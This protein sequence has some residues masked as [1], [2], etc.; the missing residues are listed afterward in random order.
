VSLETSAKINLGWIKP[1]IQWKGLPVTRVVLL[2]LLAGGFVLSVV[3]HDSHQGSHGQPSSAAAL[4]N[5]TA[6]RLLFGNFDVTNQVS[7]WP[8]CSP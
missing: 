7:I 1:F 8:Q 3:K 2:I 5:E 6:M 4:T